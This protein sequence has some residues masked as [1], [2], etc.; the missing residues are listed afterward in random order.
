MALKDIIMLT[1]QVSVG[2]IVTFFA[3]L[4]W[5]HTRE[6]EWMLVILGALLKYVEILV[7][8]LILLGVIQGDIYIIPRYVDVELL[9]KILPQLF[10]GAA[11]IVKLVK[12]MR[13]TEY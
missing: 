9:L 7:H 10:Y 3:I 6:I 11:F 8:T 5:S 12:I 1:S 2:A 13:G 4:L